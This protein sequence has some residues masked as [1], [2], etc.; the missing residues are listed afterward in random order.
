[1]LYRTTHLYIDLM[2]PEVGG[3][4]LRD[5]PAQDCGVG[6]CPGHLPE[7]RQVVAWRDNLYIS[8]VQTGSST[9][10]ESFQKPAS[11]RYETFCLLSRSVYTRLYFYIETWL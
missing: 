6:L 4:H 10:I 1:M 3:L 7:S 5:I 9:V 11:S 2:L 8:R